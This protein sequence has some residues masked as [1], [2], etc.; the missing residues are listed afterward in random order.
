MGLVMSW[1]ILAGGGLSRSSCAPVG[2]AWGEAG[3][4]AGLKVPPPLPSPYPSPS[5]LRKT[6]QSSRELEQLVEV[7]G[8]LG[9]QRRRE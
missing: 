2:V 7:H 9:G 8:L 3:Q 5:H 6:G 1:R 4:V